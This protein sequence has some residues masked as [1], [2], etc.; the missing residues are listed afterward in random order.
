[1]SGFMSNLVEPR[2]AGLLF[3]YGMRKWPMN[4]AVARFIG[5]IEKAVITVAVVFPARVIQDRVKADSV[6]RQTAIDCREY[7]IADQVEPLCACAVF[8]TG[9]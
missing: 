4:I 1:M 5:V 7:F 8:R 6:D 3:A 9:F 2:E